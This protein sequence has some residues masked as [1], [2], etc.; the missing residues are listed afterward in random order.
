[1]KTKHFWQLGVEYLWFLYYSG[2]SNE[3]LDAEISACVLQ[4]INVT[5]SGIHNKVYKIF[6]EK[7]S[8]S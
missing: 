5:D 6:K 1:V 2:E 8:V 4:L 3:V 7:I